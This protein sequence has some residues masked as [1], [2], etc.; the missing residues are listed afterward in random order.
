MQTV[1]PVGSGPTRE[2]RRLIGSDKVEGTPVRR[3]NGDKLGEI[4]RVM[5]DKR[6]GRVVYAVMSFGG[7]LGM[8][9][10]YYPIPWEKL[11]YNVEL[12]A[13]ELDI[14]EDQLRG[15]PKHA[16]E[17]Y[18]WNNDEDARIFSYWGATPYWTF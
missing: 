12:D 1:T 11:K 15:A 13:Y 6:S 16:D 2:T 18:Y 7:F 5:I 8:G 9:E 4:E 10:D 14:T 17:G 3:A